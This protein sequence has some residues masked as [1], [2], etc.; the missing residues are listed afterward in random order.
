MNSVQNAKRDDVIHIW[1]EV[2]MNYWKIRME[3]MVNVVVMICIHLQNQRR[4]ALKKKKLPEGG[5]TNQQSAARGRARRRMR[6]PTQ[7]ERIARQPDNLA[8]IPRP[9]FSTRTIAYS[10]VVL[11]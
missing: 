3:G 10:A 6:I 7:E 2:W 5:S 9:Q 8:A 1:I 11:V 4:R